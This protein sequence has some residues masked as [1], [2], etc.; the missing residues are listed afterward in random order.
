MYDPAKRI[1][2]KRA[3]KHK[4]FDDLDISSLPETPDIA[5]VSKN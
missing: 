2:A 5:S 4:Y 3:L 1:S